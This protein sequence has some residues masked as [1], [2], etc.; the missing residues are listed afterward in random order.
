M[1]MRFE[2]KAWEPSIRYDDKWF[3]D[4]VGEVRVV[5]YEANILDMEL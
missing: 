4:N 5:E 3:F 1:N 2:S